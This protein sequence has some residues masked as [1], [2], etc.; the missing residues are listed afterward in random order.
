M[1][2][3]RTI[4]ELEAQISALKKQ[5][6]NVAEESKKK[7]EKLTSQI[8]TLKA[9]NNNLME[10]L[11]LSKKKMFG[12]SAEKIAESYGQISFF[13]E[14]EQ[15]RTL[16]TPEPSIEEVVI[17]KHTRKK[18]RSYNEI[19]KDLPVEE[20]IY[21][22]PEKDKKCNKC[23]EKLTFLKYETRREIKM[24]PAKFPSTATYTEVPVPEVSGQEI[25]CSA[26][27]FSLPIRTSCP[28]T[29]ARMPKPA[30]S[31]T[32]ESIPEVLSGSSP[33]RSA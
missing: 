25:F 19:Y 22:I 3:S 1:D 27:S 2:N 7:E 4:I 9:E 29:M 24:I 18:K 17:P 12:S 5:L 31:F 6:K 16:L 13:N 23:G 32:S 30:S 20:V 14:A 11:K 26:K 10:L 8:N 15:E 28:L 33:V 21:D